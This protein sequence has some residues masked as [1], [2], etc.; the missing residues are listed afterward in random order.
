MIRSI[1]IVTRN[2]NVLQEKQKNLSANTA[3][4]TT[5]GFKYQEL[6]QSTL[7]S[8]VALN[9]AGGVRMNQRQELGDFTFGNQIDEAVIHMD[10]GNL[11][12]TGIPTDYAING[13]G[14]FT[15]DSPNGVLY[16]Q[17]GRFTVNET[18]QLVTAE[19]YTVQTAG[20]QPVITSFGANVNGLESVDNGY[21]TGAGGIVDDG[22]STLYQ[23]YLESSNIEMADVMVDMLQITREFEANQKVLQASNETLQKAT[24]EIGKV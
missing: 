13:D 17:N 10:E 19:G 22:N 21:F 14:F 12:E 8:E 18:G 16:T 2:F 4:V 23:G 6:I 1:D 5:P 11:Q 24:N 3:N 15:V 9:H 20:G 7:P